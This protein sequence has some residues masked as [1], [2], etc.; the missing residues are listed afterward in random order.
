MRVRAVR[1]ERLDEIVPA[2][3]LAEGFPEVTP[4]DFVEFFCSTHKGCEPGNE[5]TRI[6]WEYLHP[7][8][9]QYALL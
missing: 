5:V 3:V 2:E 1:R 4:A 8:A 6:E 7:G 9:E